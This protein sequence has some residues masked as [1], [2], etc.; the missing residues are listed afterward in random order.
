MKALQ[1]N[2]AVIVRLEHLDKHQ[3]QRILDFI[4]GSPYAIAGRHLKVGSAVFLFTPYNI[5]MQ[6]TL[7]S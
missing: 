3:A 4:S 5:Q 1:E 7:R 2:K 6:A